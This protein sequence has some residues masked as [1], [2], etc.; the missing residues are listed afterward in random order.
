[1]VKSLVKS[2][3]SPQIGLK[4][5]ISP[6]ISN[7]KRSL[8]MDRVHGE[9]FDFKPKPQ[10]LEKTTTFLVINNICALTKLMQKTILY[11]LITIF[12]MQ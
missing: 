12:A 9:I 6:Q 11:N 2:L 4:S 10:K 1:M 3:I 7:Q 5:K 8:C